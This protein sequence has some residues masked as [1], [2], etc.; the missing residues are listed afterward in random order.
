MMT[1]LY[2]SGIYFVITKD[3]NEIFKFGKSTSNQSTHIQAGTISLE[4]FAINIASGNYVIAIRPDTADNISAANAVTIAYNSVHECTF[5]S[6][7]DNVGANGQTRRLTITGDCLLTFNAGST[8]SGG[9]SGSSSSSCPS[10]GSCTY[11][12]TCTK[13][14]HPCSGINDAYCGGN[15]SSAYATNGYYDVKCTST[16]SNDACK[17]CSPHPQT[18]RIVADYNTPGYGGSTTTNSNANCDMGCTDSTPFTITAQSFWVKKCIIYGAGI[19]LQPILYDGSASQDS[20][21]NYYCSY[22]WTP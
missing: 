15:M 16:W 9:S 22:T 18:V 6:S 17:N 12:V 19:G 1:D 21:G 11:T 4:N 20:D 10:S 8:S 7:P 13:S 5:S 14:P 2:D 3:G